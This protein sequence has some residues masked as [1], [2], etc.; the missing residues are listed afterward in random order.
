[1]YILIW[2]RITIHTHPDHLTLLPLPYKDKLPGYYIKTSQIG[3]LHTILAHN[4]YTTC[5]LSKCRLK[6][7]FT[8]E[9]SLRGISFWG[10]MFS[11]K[12]TTNGMSSECLTHFL[13]YGIKSTLISL[14]QQQLIPKQQYHQ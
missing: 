9:S 1:M 6:K 14:W 3:N 4:T 7:R 5:T 13:Y 12:E 2:H 10:A 8:W 11:V